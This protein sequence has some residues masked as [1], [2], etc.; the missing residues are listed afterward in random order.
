MNRPVAIL[1]IL[2]GLGLGV[3][4]CG[5]EAG[6]ESSSASATPTNKASS[7]AKTKTS[8]A[9]AASSAAPAASSAAP[10]TSS[11]AAPASSADPDACPKDNKPPAFEYA[12]VPFTWSQ[13]PELKS[14][15][16]DKAYANVGDKTFVLPK[17]EVWISEKE[18]EISLRTNDGVL[19][20]PTLIFKGEPKAGMTLED[21][22]GNNRG[23]FQMPKKGTTAECS[24]QTTS[25]NGSNA[26]IVKLDKY[27][28]KTADVTFVTTWEAN[29]N[30]AKQQ[31]WAAGTVK[32]AKVVIFK[33]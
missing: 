1:S 4:A 12:E 20:G 22:W 17:V 25:F 5:P 16:K 8:A 27:D 3:A 32:D 18:G 13:T 2:F 19:L 21:K 10:A 14:A 26:R 6:P 15:P 7:S 30:G 9:P 28:G 11:S 24:A 33:K 23:Y 31:L 29:M